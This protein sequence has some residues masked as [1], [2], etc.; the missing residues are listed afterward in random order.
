M[1]NRFGDR[2][3]GV[4]IRERV[5]LWVDRF[6]SL[7]IEGVVLFL[8][9]CLLQVFVMAS[10]RIPSDS[11]EPGLTAGDCILV[12][13]LVQGPRLF[14]LRKAFSVEDVKIYRMP[15]WGSIGRNDVVVINFMIIRMMSVDLLNII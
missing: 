9:W 1:E 11:M 6:F 12:N 4:R 8:V 14:N 3:R 2:S 5:D 13:K 15:G 10:F 7:C